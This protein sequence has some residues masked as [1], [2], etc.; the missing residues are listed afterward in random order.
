MIRVPDQVRHAVEQRAEG[1]C[2]Y[3]HA[4]QV[5]LGYRLHVEHTIHRA[6]DGANDLDN[7]A[8]SCSTCNFAKGALTAGRDPASGA[9]SPLF[10]P[11]S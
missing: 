2:E 4:P 7:L 5:I 10:N 9:R 1:H 3:C 6:R 11:R 8:L